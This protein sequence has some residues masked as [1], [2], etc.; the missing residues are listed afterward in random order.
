SAAM[1][2]TPSRPHQDWPPISDFHSGPQSVPEPPVRLEEGSG[3][4]VGR[5]ALFVIFAKPLSQLA[6]GL[7]DAYSGNGQAPK[8]SRLAANTTVV[9][10]QPSPSADRAP[11]PANKMA[12]AAAGS[13]PI[14]EPQQYALAQQ[15]VR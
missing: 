11:A 6:T 1:V 2:P 9:P 4:L 14:A 13:V 7:F 10:E 3:G 5:V 12:V 15:P 8:T